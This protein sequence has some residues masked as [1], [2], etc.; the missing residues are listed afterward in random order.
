MDVL[1]AL[2]ENMI[3]SYSVNSVFRTAIFLDFQVMD[4]F[5]TSLNFMAFYLLGRYVNAFVKQKRFL[6][7]SKHKGLKMEVAILLNSDHSGNVT[8]KELD[9]RLMQ[10]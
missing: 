1:I 2:K 7:M 9:T 10:E 6:V 4:F 8:R 3:Y 5:R